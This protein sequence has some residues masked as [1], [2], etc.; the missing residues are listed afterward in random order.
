MTKEFTIERKANKWAVYWEEV[1]KGE[2][3][4]A[5]IREYDSDKARYSIEEGK[6][7]G[8]LFRVKVAEITQ[9]VDL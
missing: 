3:L 2:T 7:Q 6:E 9:V 4:Q 8:I 5:A 1:A